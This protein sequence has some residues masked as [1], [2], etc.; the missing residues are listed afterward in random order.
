M[1]DEERTTM[2]SKAE[3]MMRMLDD[4]HQPGV[5]DELVDEFYADGA[6]FEDPLQRA[7]GLRAIK[8][9]WRSMTTIFDAIDGEI[10]SEVEQGNQCVVQW[11]MRFKYKVWPVEVTLPGVTW[12][13]LDDAGKCT[14]HVDYWDVW[15]FLR[16]SF[17]VVKPV[18]RFFPPALRRLLA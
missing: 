3:T 8:K 1:N 5:I 10:I 11:E 6:Y 13:T 4:I 14:S 16:R 17:P 2:L 9:M 15:A 12:L 7:E 18:V